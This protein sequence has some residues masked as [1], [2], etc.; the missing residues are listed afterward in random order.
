MVPKD[1]KIKSTKK[2]ENYYFLHP[3]HIFAFFNRLKR[4]ITTPCFYLY[5]IPE[6]LK[7]LAT[8]SYALMVFEPFSLFHHGVL[9][10]IR[11]LLHDDSLH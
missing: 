3:E 2:N 1:R 6:F 4:M 7:T 5:Q 9:I 8:T 11:V 10:L